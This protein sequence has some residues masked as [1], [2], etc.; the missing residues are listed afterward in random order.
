[1]AEPAL[2]NSDIKASLSFLLYAPLF[3][4]QA[5]LAGYFLSVTRHSTGSKM[6]PRA[7]SGAING[8]ENCRKT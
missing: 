5:D 2:F 7:A 4:C 6:K 3:L 8:Q 1:M